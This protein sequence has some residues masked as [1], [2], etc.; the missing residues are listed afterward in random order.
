MRKPFIARL[1]FQASGVSMKTAFAVVVA[2]LIACLLAEGGFAQ[3]TSRFQSVGGDYGRNVINSLKAPAPA[4][5]SQSTAASNNS[6]NSLWNWGTA[7]KGSMI[8]EG[9]LI[10]DPRYAMKNLSVVANWL[11]DSFVDP[12]GDTPTYSY[13][14]PITGQPIKTY[15]DPNTG[16][17]YYTYTD[18]KTG[19]LVYVY[20]NP[21]TGEPTYA[22]FTPISGQYVEQKQF[23]LPPIFSS[24]G[25]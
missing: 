12:Y 8:V 14:D 21:E 18:S 6:N 16:Q 1:L 23:A 15:V 24:N 25:L 22:S 19:R 5:D 13:T 9:N 11:G 17:S 3:S 7:P 10:D 20:F 4:P 2:L